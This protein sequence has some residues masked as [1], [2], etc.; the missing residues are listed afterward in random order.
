MAH[1][2]PLALRE[3][4]LSFTLAPHF[5]TFTSIVAIYNI[6]FA[7]AKEISLTILQHW[8]PQHTATTS[9]GG[10]F[11]SFRSPHA[12]VS[13]PSRGP[14]APSRSHHYV[15]TL[16]SFLHKDLLLHVTLCVSL[17][18]GKHLQRSKRRH[19]NY[20]ESCSKPEFSSFCESENSIVPR[21]L[22]ERYVTILL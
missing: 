6:T 4:A 11:P 9:L 17:L 8:P 7:K 5:P 19:R 22:R 15:I 13:R 21:S 2:R 20:R 16:L 14:R 12:H 3:P 18:D 10:R 1:S